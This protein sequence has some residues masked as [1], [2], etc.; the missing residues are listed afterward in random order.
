MK[1]STSQLKCF[2]IILFSRNHFEGITKFEL[3]RN[4]YYKVIFICC[5]GYMILCRSFSYL[6]RMIYTCTIKPEYSIQF[7]FCLYSPKV[8][9]ECVLLHLEK[10]PKTIVHNSFL[11]GLIMHVVHYLSISFWVRF[12]SLENILEVFLLLR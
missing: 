12:L 11:L 2:S 8:I 7:S 6:Q 4:Q 5:L 10:Y 3:P 1:I 9:E